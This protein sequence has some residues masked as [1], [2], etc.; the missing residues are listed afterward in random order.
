VSQK[1]PRLDLKPSAQRLPKL[2]PVHRTCPVC[3][4]TFDLRIL[5]HSF[6]HTDQPHGPLQLKPE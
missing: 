3:G 4:Q 5:A 2:E 6:H 1:L